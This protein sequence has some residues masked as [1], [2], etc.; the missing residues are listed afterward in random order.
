[1]SAWTGCSNGCGAGLQ[2]RTVVCK[3]I[4]SNTVGDTYCSVAGA[5]PATQQACQGVT[6]CGYSWAV[7]GW[8]ACSN[9]CTGGYQTRDVYCRRTDGSI[10]ADAYCGG[11]PNTV[12]QCSNPSAP[13]CAPK[14]TPTHYIT[15]GSFAYSTVVGSFMNWGY[16][17]GRA[18]G[19]SPSISPLNGLMM[20][21]GDNIGRHQNY[22]WCMNY[23]SYG[24]C[25]APA[26][27]FKIISTGEEYSLNS[28]VYFGG[29]CNLCSGEISSLSRPIP[30]NGT[31]LPVIFR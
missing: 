19:I 5:K 26:R 16:S 2:Y 20:T 31:V 12:Q 29:S 9:N 27:Y 4:N 18:G 13:E 22:K 6:S 8:S 23:A 7:G 30:P 17:A 25:S 15:V 11:K 3:D 10:V 24:K 21:N 14:E 28:N 1:M